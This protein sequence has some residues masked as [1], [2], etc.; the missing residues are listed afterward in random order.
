MNRALYDGDGYATYLFR[1]GNNSYAYDLLGVHAEKTEEGSYRYTF[2]VYAPRAERVFVIGD[3]LSHE[4][5]ILMEKNPASGIWNAVLESQCSLDRKRYQYKIV[6]ENGTCYKADPYARYAET[7]GGTFS[8]IWQG[9]DF[10]WNDEPW[11]KKK[12][13]FF[14]VRDPK[15]PHF[16]SA[17]LNIYEIHLGSWRTRDAES[18]SENGRYLNYREI[19]DLLAPYLADMHYTHAE[20]LPITEHPFDGSWGYQSLG[21][22]AP[23]SRFGTP[24]DF[25]YFVDKLHEYGIGVIL[26]FVP[27]HF[28]KDAHGLIDFDGAPLYEYGD[29]SRRE[30]V[31]WGM[32]NFDVG[33]PEVQSFLISSALFWMREYHVD[34]LRIGAVAS[35]LYLDYG[36]EPG[37]WNP[38]I[39]GNSHNLEAISFFK[40]LNTALFAEF[41]HSL[42]IAEDTTAWPMLT[43][44]AYEGGLGFNFKW[45][46]G[47]SGG[48]FDYIALDPV[49]RQH[50]HA[51]L[52]FPMMYAFS[53]NYILPVSHDDV[54]KGKKSLADKM[55]GSC[56]EKLAA[57]RAFMTFMMTLPGKKLLFMGSEYATLSEWSHE[58]PLDCFMAE[59]PHHT[60]MKRCI[61]KLNE[62]YLCEPPLHEIDDGWD[63]F[64]WLEPNDKHRNTV[65]YRRISID[66]EEL[67]V[68]VNFSPVMWEDYVLSVP[69]RGDYDEIFTTDAKE[70]GGSGF[71]NGTLRSKQHKE[72]S[73]MISEIRL[74]IPPYGGI[75][76]R[77][78]GIQKKKTAK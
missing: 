4:E 73:K 52:T 14:A 17:P 66:G 47:F 34:G 8:L 58:K 36:R 74:T 53:E 15:R 20:L 46:T 63:G 71:T 40:K 25:K 22:F 76:F 33:R 49:E 75:I 50:H 72:N 31:K 44:P 48:M 23:T 55:F 37:E 13:E 43:K 26:D 51:K 9:D 39:Y 21:F 45:N 12:A 68:A 64:A 35:M 7:D 65:C 54:A 67:I 6:S 77:R 60:E 10:R 24:T 28:P 5:E 70:F 29:E 3:F 18:N 11:Q 69:K 61:K 30:D 1:Q 57:T 2:R 78:R 38:N 41:P 59:Y 16:Y 62:L 19:A 27:A 56:D 42:M 32:L